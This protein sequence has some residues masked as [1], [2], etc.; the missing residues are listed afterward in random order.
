MAEELSDLKQSISLLLREQ[1]DHR[2]AVERNITDIQRELTNIKENHLRSLEQKEDLEALRS[3]RDHGRIEDELNDINS[4]TIEKLQAVE[5]TL[6]KIKTKQVKIREDIETSTD[7]GKQLIFKVD[8]NAQNTQR[9][10]ATVNENSEEIKTGHQELK[11]DFEALQNECKQIADKIDN[12]EQ[13]TNTSNDNL[14]NLER[15]QLGI[16]NSL[17]VLRN[18]SEYRARIVESDVAN[19][20]EQLARLR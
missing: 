9:I 18:Q 3:E 2:H 19:I 10:L 15:G 16:E 11:E 8:M 6:E 20:K 14:E 1:A 4:E 17:Q 7:Q 5:K 13:E 12:M